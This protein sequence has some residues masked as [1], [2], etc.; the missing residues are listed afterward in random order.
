[1]FYDVN[2]SQ[3]HCSLGLKLLLNLQAKVI[4]H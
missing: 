2:M 1:M 3:H 4:W